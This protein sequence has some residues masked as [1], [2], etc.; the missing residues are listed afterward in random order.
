MPP[1]E[2]KPTHAICMDIL[3]ILQKYP[4]KRM[5]PSSGPAPKNL[6]H[7]SFPFSYLGPT[8]RLDHWRAARA[9]SWRPRTRSS[10]T[11][12]AIAA[13]WAG[14]PN[15]TGLGLAVFTAASGSETVTLVLKVSLVLV[16]QAVLPGRTIQ[17]HSIL[18][19]RKRSK[20]GG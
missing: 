16:V 12:Q 1:P 4:Q 18:R 8:S 17:I 3:R 5:L 6:P 9:R 14:D 7:F 15:K 20:W 13:R 19:R 11:T 2:T 10:R